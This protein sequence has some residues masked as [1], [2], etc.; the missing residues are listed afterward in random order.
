M[1]L[2]TSQVRTIMPKAP[3]ERASQFAMYFTQ[4]SD[5][6]GVDTPARAAAFLAQVAHECAELNTLTEN[7][8]YSAERLLQVFPKYFT[9]SN[10]N[11]YARNPQ[12]IGNRV[13]ANRMG[14]GS[15]GSGDGYRYRGRGCFQLTGRGNYQDYA[16]S[17]LCSGDLMGHPEWLAQFP[18]AVK[19]ALWFWQSR[20]LNKYADRGD[21][22]G[23]TKAINGGYNG[24]ESRQ[25]YWERAKKVFGV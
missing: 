19:S 21:F 24:L 14:N 16:N 25:K 22:R 20:K 5:R 2:T 9:V 6:F 12:K 11:Y 23:L 7:L 8:N 1:K 15:E 4:W 17:P 10:V 3:Y 18:G 13:Y